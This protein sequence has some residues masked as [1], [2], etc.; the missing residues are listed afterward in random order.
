MRKF[1]VMRV[2]YKKLSQN[3][4]WFKL[5]MTREEDGTFQFRSQFEIL[6]DQCKR[7]VCVSEK[8]AIKRFLK[9]VK[10]Y[11]NPIF[12]AVDE[13]TLSILFKK[14]KE[15]RYYSLLVHGYTFWRRILK[16]SSPFVA[17]FLPLASR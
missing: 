17:D 10:D 9:F 3:P 4:S 8:E 1:L 14:V 15:H 2:M 16:W 12:V 7:I 6:T 11:S 13:D 5:H